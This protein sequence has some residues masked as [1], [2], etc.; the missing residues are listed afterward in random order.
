MR[1]SLCVSCPQQP[2]RTFNFLIEL[3]NADGS[4][5][6]VMPQLKQVVWPVGMLP[7]HMM[8]QLKST[9]TQAVPEMASQHFDLALLD[10]TNAQVTLHD[11]IDFNNLYK[12]RICLLNHF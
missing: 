11:G 3:A 7:D 4:L 1:Q 2:Q 6:E 8:L 12:V 9:V 5:R 10:Q